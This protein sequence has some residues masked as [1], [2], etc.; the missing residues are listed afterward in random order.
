M[1]N[2]F[3]IIFCLIFYTTI[4]AQTVEVCG[5][6]SDPSGY[7]VGFSGIPIN[8]TDSNGN[9]ICET[10]S[11]IDGAYCCQVDESNYPLIICPKVICLD[12]GGLSVLDLVAIVNYILDLPNP[13]AG[14][15]GI[16][17][18]NFALW[19]DANGDGKVTGADI[20]LL[21]KV[22]LAIIGDFNRCRIVSDD[23]I[24]DWTYDNVIYH[25]Y[26]LG[27]CS[28][29]SEIGTNTNFSLY[30][31]GNVNLSDP[32]LDCAK[33]LIQNTV[34][35]RAF[36]NFPSFTISSVSK[37][38]DSFAT[39]GQFNTLFL[40]ISLN[41]DIKLSEINIINSS[42]DIEIIDNY[43]FLFYANR[44]DLSDLISIDNSF[45]ILNIEGISSN[46]Q[47]LSNIEIGDK[48]ELNVESVWYDIENRTIK[49]KNGS[50]DFRLIEITNESGTLIYNK[51]F[52][53]NGKIDFEINLNDIKLHEGLCFAKTTNT[54]NS[55]T[56]I[57]IPFL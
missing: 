50:Q 39:L 35:T 26:C 8:I 1:K 25:E 36:E 7:C 28:Y 54:D 45:K 2:L 42:T 20:V 16:F 5:T 49:F 44:K 57:K 48:K 3:S 22:M 9:T 15:N 6:I 12:N 14:S 40:K 51:P 23:C 34:E 31:V 24:E 33:P 4:S 11:G 32:D 21:R 18:S 55:S 46:K 53:I 30:S 56:I 29:V 19:A 13:I 41:G 47:V 38:Y 43:V 10:T 52:V 27:G 17:P 37:K